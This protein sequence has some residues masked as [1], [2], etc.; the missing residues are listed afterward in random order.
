MGWNY[1][2]IPKLQQLHRW[3]LGTDAL[4]HLKLYWVCACV[5]ML[6]FKLIYVRKM[7]YRMLVKRVSWE[8]NDADTKLQQSVERCFEIHFLVWKSFTFIQNDSKSL[9]MVQYTSL[10]AWVNGLAMNMRQATIWINGG[11][12][13]WC[14][15]ESLRLDE[16]KSM[17]P[18]TSM[19][20]THK[21]EHNTYAHDCVIKTVK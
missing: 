2:S 1:L 21:Y 8:Q 7:A 17:I 18:Q 10:I 4:F 13:L 5:S 16:L 6:G 12:V 15:Y 14:I 20:I 3:S 9:Q 19:S 11:P